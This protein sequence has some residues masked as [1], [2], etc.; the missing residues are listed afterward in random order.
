MNIEGYLSADETAGLLGV[1]LTSLYTYVYRLEGFPQPRRI[2]R[3][4][5]FEEAAVRAWRDQHPAKP[6]TTATKGTA[7]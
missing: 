2:G 6:R 3:T 4:L 5:L 7:D 1:K